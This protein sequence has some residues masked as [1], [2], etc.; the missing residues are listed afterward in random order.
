MKRQKRDSKWVSGCV[1]ISKKVVTDYIWVYSRSINIEHLIEEVD[2]YF[3][4]HMLANKM[5]TS[6]KFKIQYDDNIVLTIKKMP[7]M[8]FEIVELASNRL[9]ESV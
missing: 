6:N 3:K 9:E 8:Q 2:F 4:Q 7:L 1:S 5:P